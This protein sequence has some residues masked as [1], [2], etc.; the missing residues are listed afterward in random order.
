MA[1]GVCVHGRL[2]EGEVKQSSLKYMHIYA[3]LKK[4]EYIYTKR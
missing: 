3:F 2:S 4:V 1:Q